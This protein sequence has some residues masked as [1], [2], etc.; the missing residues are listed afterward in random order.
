MYAVINA[1]YLKVKRI[2]EKMNVADFKKFV[3]K[4]WKE[5]GEN[6]KMDYQKEYQE[7]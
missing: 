7:D 5:E 1:R 6:L 2:A 3:S 4:L